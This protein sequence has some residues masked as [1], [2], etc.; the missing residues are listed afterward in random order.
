VKVLIV[1][2][3]SKLMTAIVANLLLFNPPAKSHRRSATILQIYG[4]SV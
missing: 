1:T 4:A 2:P 3:L